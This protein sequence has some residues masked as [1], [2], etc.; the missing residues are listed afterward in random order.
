MITW[1]DTIDSTNSEVTRRIDS[2]GNL[3]VIAAYEQ[4]LGRGQGDH[5]W[6]S[7]KA[8]NLTFTVALKFPAEDTE[9]ERPVLKVG[10]NRLLTDATTYALCH[11]LKSRGIAPRI[12]WINDIYVDMDKICGILIETVLDRGVVTG[13]IIGIGLNLNQTEFPDYLP[14]PTSMKIQTGENYVIERELEA[15][16][17]HMALA[18]EML[19]SPLGRQ[20][21]STYYDTHVF[22]LK[23]G[24]F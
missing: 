14:N 20:A 21:L 11:Y 7:H 17:E 3:D 4:T 22:H 23:Q 12:K 6:H 24:T 19:D 13:A 1:L 5:K 18:S 15:F 16:M 8:E 10:D 2:L 9:G